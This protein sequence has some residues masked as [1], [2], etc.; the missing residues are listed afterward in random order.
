MLKQLAFGGEQPS[1]LEVLSNLLRHTELEAGSA[2]RHP[3][4]LVRHDG[5]KKRIPVK[6][7]ILIQELPPPLY[8]CGVPKPKGAVQIAQI[9]IA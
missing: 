7:A 9:R 2:S 4:G 6:L 1:A 8:E 5:L 3:G